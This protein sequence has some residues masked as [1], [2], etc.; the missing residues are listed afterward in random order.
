MGDYVRNRV[1]ELFAEDKLY[2][3]ETV[4]SVIAE[5]GGTKPGD[6]V[7]MATGFCSGEGRT[8]GQC[9]ALSGA[10]MGIGL[11]A[12]RDEPG[13]DYEPAYALVHELIE[14]FTNKFDSVNCFELLQCDL[15]SPEGQKRFEEKRLKRKCVLYAAFAAQ[16]A[17]D[18][19]REHGYLPEHEAFIRSRLAP[20]GLSCGSCLA[21]KGSRIQRL[22][23]ALA[24][25]LGENFSA[26]AER[27]AGMNPVF[28]NY[29]RFRELLDFMASGSCTGCREQGCL[30]KTCT[31][32]ACAGEH[33]VAYCFECDE[34]PCDRHGMPPGLAERWRANNE[35]MRDKG[36]ETWYSG[37]MDRKRYP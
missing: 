1:L 20:C 32:A 4:L 25:E 7:R 33:G 23:A 10:V 21:F 3:A 26:Y 28:E 24:E 35:V 5:A 6:A 29:A 16:T 18:L 9:G 31:V 12:G 17:L 19:L 22:S 8:C 2:C 13:G 27:F 30:F 11:Y 34:F 36:V 15:G 14:K 37:C